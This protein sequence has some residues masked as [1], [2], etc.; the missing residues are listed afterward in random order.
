MGNLFPRSWFSLLPS[1]VLGSSLWSEIEPFA[2]AILY[3]AFVFFIL[4]FIDT[5]IKK[6][7]FRKEKKI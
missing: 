5:T 6:I 2:W 1:D 7:F 3:T 4:L